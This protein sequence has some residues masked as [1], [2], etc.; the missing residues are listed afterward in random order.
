MPA[1]TF[2]TFSD[3]YV[4]DK[5]EEKPLKGTDVTRS[6]E[7]TREFAEHLIIKYS[8]VKYCVETK[9]LSF[10]NNTIHLYC[11]RIRMKTTWVLQCPY[12]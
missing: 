5:R 12:D 1:C 11:L 7:K 3:R 6:I 2:G 8:V 9:M 4:S 10:C